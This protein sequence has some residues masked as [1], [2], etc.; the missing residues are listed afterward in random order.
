MK[1][2][3][4]FPEFCNL[5]GDI[6]NIDYLHK[7]IPEAEIINTAIDEEPAFLTQDINLIYLGPL[8]EKKQ[9]IV[10]NK[11]KPYKE[12]IEELINNNTPFLFTGNAV[13]VLGKYIENE[14]GTSIEGLGIFNVCAK[15][16]MM[17]RF[18]C[19][20][21]GQYED[22][23]IVGFKSQFTMLYGDNDKNYFINTK[24]GIGIN[25]TT[26]FEGIKQNNF[27]GTYVIGPLLILNPLFTEKLLKTMGVE[28]PK[29]AFKEDVIA[30]YEERLRKYKELTKK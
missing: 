3:V 27:F 26:I 8:T 20:Y 22:I 11:L 13:E 16:N 28:T 25:N 12:N 10:I 21:L 4:L 30:A 5:Y 18:N 23:E 14:D 17:Q 7:C 6:S 1:I 15:R 2:E 9:E 24:M 29:I 19:L